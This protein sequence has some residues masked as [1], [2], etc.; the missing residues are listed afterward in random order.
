MSFIVEQ[1]VEN[2]ALEMLQEMGYEIVYAPELAPDGS[3]PQRKE[4]DTVVLLNVL[5]ASLKKLNPDVPEDAI[6]EAIKKITKTSSHKIIV[7]NEQFHE[8]VINGVAVE[9]REKGKVKNSHLRIFDRDK[10]GRNTFQALNQF[11]I[12]ENKHNRRPDVIIFING[13]PV[14]IIELKNPASATATVKSAFDQIETY[15]DEIP[16]L[17]TY[18]EFVII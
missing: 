18:N 15:K 9:H 16:S 11:T 8:F 10:P 1:D 12:I 14:G 6:Q 4:W 13:L 17:F 7:N 2:A 3:N 5:E